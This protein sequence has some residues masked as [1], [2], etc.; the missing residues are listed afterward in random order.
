MKIIIQGAPSR[1]GHQAKI[2]K[3]SD[4]IL[5]LGA[6]SANIKNGTS[7]KVRKANWYDGGGPVSDEM[8]I[9]P[10]GGGIIRNPEDIQKQ[11]IYMYFWWLRTTPQ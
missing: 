11:R 9:I 8:V 5:Y 6:F 7:L 4:S 3:T 10:A 2:S 1:Q